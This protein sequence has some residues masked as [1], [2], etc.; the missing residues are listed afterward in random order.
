MKKSA[1]RS[2][3]SDSVVKGKSARAKSVS[4]AKGGMGKQRKKTCKMLG[5]EAELKF[6]SRVAELGLRVAKPFGDSAP[7]DVIVEGEKEFHR[8]QVKSTRYLHRN[9]YSVICTWGREH[10]HYGEDDIDQLVVLIVPLGVWYVIPVDIVKRKKA[11]YFSV[12]KG[13]RWGKYR[14][15][16]EALF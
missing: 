13:E 3:A 4:S 7:Y 14:E 5:E 6:M 15:A 1:V 12:K 10:S 11:L 16:W 2:C 8:V 9:Q